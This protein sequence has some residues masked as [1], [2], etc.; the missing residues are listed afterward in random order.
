MADGKIKVYFGCQHIAPID[1]IQRE[2][3]V[4]SLKVAIYA[5][6]GSGKTFISRLFRFLE[7]PHANLSLDSNDC[8]PT[9][10]LIRF[11]YKTGNF[12]F[13]ITDR[14][15]NKVEDISL[16]IQKNCVPNI[17]Y[18]NYL[19]HVFNQDYVEENI[20]VL[21][22]EKDSDI[23][24][25]ILGKAN[26]DLTDDE[27]IL[28]KIEAESVELRTRIESSIKAYIAEHIDSIRDIKR[29]QEYRDFLNVDAI[30]NSVNQENLYCDKALEELIADYDKVKSVPENLSDIS[31][32]DNISIDIDQLINDLIKAYTLSSFSD[33][34]K[35]K[36]KSK[37]DFIEEGLKLFQN[38]ICPFCEQEVSAASIWLIDN[39]TKFLNDSESKTIKLFQ[40]Y[41]RQLK[42]YILLL[43]DVENTMAK[44]ESTYNE[45]KTK[46]I[47]SLKNVSLES[48]SVVVSSLKCSIQ[49][50]LVDVNKK[51]EAID[52][53][54]RVDESIT[55]DIKKYILALN[56]LIEN[57]NKK[58]VIINQRKNKI[59]EE[60]RSIRRE[61]C[62]SAHSYLVEYYN[63]DILQLNEL[64]KKCNELKSD[65][66][67]RRE[68]EK[69]SKKKRV[70]E[71]IKS[72]LDYF[73][74]GKY[75]L[76]EDDFHLIFNNTSLEKGQVKNVLSEGEKNIIAFAYYLGDAHLKI[77][78]EDDYDKLF[79]VIDDPISSMDFTYVYTLCGVIRD[80]KQI[81]ENI[82]REKFIILTHNNDFMR[83]LCAN[84]ITEKRL[85]LRNGSLVDFNENFTVPYISHLIDVYRIAR[86][87]EHAKHTTANSIRH[88]IETLTK[89]Q[90]IEVSNS[91]ISEYI[92]ENI[93]NDK[94][95]Y[96][97]INDLSHG[98]WRS[99]QE[100]I[101][102][103]DY[104]E[105]CETIIAHIEILFPN[106]IRYCEKFNDNIS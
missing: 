83:I 31:L 90:N 84:N 24:G 85:L 30:L 50:L 74:S 87:G 101:T 92:K 48:V 64:R 23:K 11:G 75:T 103:D 26:I 86:N 68:S 70:Y 42:E 62:K 58:I 25:Y 28:K 41:G 71:T 54:I 10:S 34:F 93:P 3:S 69:I 94:K 61:I 6:N 32:V 8:S 73:F 100:P 89:F 52:V 46:Y 38:N 19:Y 7:L 80:I 51:C 102:D 49:Q 76:N 99:E 12:A 44:R 29:L 15:G 98:G 40:N 47:P 1:N 72:V 88:I 63:K 22:Y 53:P 9:D 78:K 104:R 27:N 95:S 39:Y 2:M 82:H 33:E 5:N 14:D 65:I 20:R 106:Q 79:F 45:Y 4:G 37:Q 66:S 59:G 16:E 18:S 77:E 56:Q 96:T 17:P 43:S 35:A 55:I 21:N 67:K 81:L 13:R 97:F 91:S 36:I 105:V 57:N 60:S